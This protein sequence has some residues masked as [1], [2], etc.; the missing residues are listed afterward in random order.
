MSKFR[1]MLMMAS[2]SEPVPPTPPLPYDAE[3]EYLE[4][5][6]TQWIGVELLGKNGYDFDYKVNF[7]QLSTSQATGIGG[8]YHSNKSCYLG[9]VR[10]NGTLAYHYKGT[11]SPVVVASNIQTGTDYVVTAHLYSGEQY[12]IVNGTKSS[13]GNITGDFVSTLY[14]RLFSVN[15]SSPLYSYMRLYY[16]KI[17]DNGILVRDYI[18]VRKDGVGYLYDKVSG[19]LFGNSGTDAFIYGNDVTT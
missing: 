18:P 12:Y 9:M 19:Q 14:L 13:V 4:S 2:L 16:C 5:T 3:V 17:Y 7:T 1:R 11:A 15:S 8:E 10:T 6:G